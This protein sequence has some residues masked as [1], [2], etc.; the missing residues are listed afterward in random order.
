VLELRSKTKH[1]EMP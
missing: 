1:N